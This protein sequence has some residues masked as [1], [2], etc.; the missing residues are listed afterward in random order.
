[1]ENFARTNWFR[2]A[3]FLAK[4]HDFATHHNFAK[5]AK[6]PGFSEIS[7]FRYAW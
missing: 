7:Y 5:L 4:I 2:Y 3:L 6:L 1:M